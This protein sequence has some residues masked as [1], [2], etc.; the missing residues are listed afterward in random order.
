MDNQNRSNQGFS[1]R[2]KTILIVDDE[3]IVAGA[4]AKKLTGAGYK[5]LVQRNGEDGLKSALATHPDLVLLDIVMPKMDGI[6]FLD[7]LRQDGWG[8]SVPVIILTNL[9]RGE[10]VEEGKSRG[11][12]DYLVK[13]DWSLSDVLS[14]VNKAIWP[15]SYASGES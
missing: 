5:V 4:L 6:T 10:K 1:P 9:E 14:K 3:E 13:T 8:K 15:K 11:V 7:K 2:D 12:Y